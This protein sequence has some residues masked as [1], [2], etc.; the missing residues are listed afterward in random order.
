MVIARVV[1]GGKGD[2]LF[3]G[4]KASVWLDNSGNVLNTINCTL[5]DDQD[6]KEHVMCILPH[7]NSLKKISDLLK[8]S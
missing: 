3:N 2:L 5:T 8:K 4:Y 6:G 1:G 7:L